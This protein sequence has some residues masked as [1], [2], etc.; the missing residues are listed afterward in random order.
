MKILEE[1]Y[2]IT[3]DWTDSKYIGL[4]LDWDYKRSKVHLS[5]QR[6]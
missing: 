2:D 6:L 4:T 5:M 3:T 1:H